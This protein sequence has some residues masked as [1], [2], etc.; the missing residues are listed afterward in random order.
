MLS[1]GRDQQIVLEIASAI[2]SPL[3]L[4]AHLTGLL[5]YDASLR[6]LLGA[7]VIIATLWMPAKRSSGTS[8]KPIINA[9]MYLLF[10]AML[11]LYMNNGDIHWLYAL[12]V[13]ALMTGYSWYQ[14]LTYRTAGT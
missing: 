8:T 7:I 12:G 10:S 13:A 1:L 6:I 11:I 3:I 4:A 14:R 5:S 2:S 9:G